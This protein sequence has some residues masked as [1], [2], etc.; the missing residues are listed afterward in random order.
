MRRARSSPGPNTREGDTLS[1]TR[2]DGAGSRS[3][4]WSRARF[5]LLGGL[6]LLSTTA[7]S[8]SDL[9]RLG[10]PTAAADQT[11]RSL[12]LWQTM[13]VVAI[14]VF[15]VTFVLILWPAVFHRR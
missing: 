1:P 11:E 12:W 4:L 15:A 5:A 2:P 7:C 13:W 6:V 3:S 14:I 10:W 9:P 8:S